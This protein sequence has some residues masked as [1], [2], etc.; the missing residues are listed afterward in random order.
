MLGKAIKMNLD[1]LWP[2]LAVEGGTFLF[3]ELIEAIIL[4]TV[5]PDTSGAICG[6]IV[7][8]VGIMMNLFSGCTYPTLNVNLLLRYSVTRKTALAATL[9]TL[10]LNMAVSMAFAA[11]LGWVDSFIAR[12]W[13]NALPWVLEVE[14]VEAP[15]WAYFVIGIG[16]VCLALGVGGMLQRFGRK[17]FWLVWALWML[18]VVGVN[19]VDVEAIV[20]LPAT[21]PAL[22]V[23]CIV[24]LVGG[25]GLILRTSVNN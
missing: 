16:V 1:D 5:K 3:Y 24:S 22:I 4:N 11:L 17:A 7:L 23:L 8:A 9:G 2:F 25:S 10:T 14:A 6:L 21:I 15:L 20:H 13:V 19:L 18:I 12:A